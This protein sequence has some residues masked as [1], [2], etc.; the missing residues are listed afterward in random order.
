MK[1]ILSIV[2]VLGFTANLAAQDIH[3]SNYDQ[4]P[5][6]LNPANTGISQGSHRAFMNYKKQWNSVSNGFK[7]MGASYDLS[8]SKSRNNNYLGMG[9]NF[10]SDKSGL[11]SMGTTLFDLFVAYHLKLDQNSSFS[12][13]IKGGIHQRSITSN[14]MQWGNQYDASMEGFNGGLTSS[15]QG[16]FGSFTNAD[17]SAGLAW[18]YNSSTSTLSSNDAF[19]ARVGFS[20]HH[21]HSPYLS[22]TG[23]QNERLARKFV[24]HGKVR[25]GIPNTNLQIEPKTVITFQSTAKEIMFGSNFRYILNEK[26]KYTSFNGGTA[27]SVGVNYR[28]KD[29]IILSSM[30]EYGKFAVGINYDIN[31]SQ[32][33]VASGGR[34]GV[35]FCLKFITPNPFGGSSDTPSF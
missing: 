35:E 34:G 21:L 27:L 9:I 33:T 32:L 24:F 31:I 30:L 11:L 20:I 10:Y 8:L 17:F 14:G 18:N 19:L 2:I 15:E 7:T 28:L 25:Y 22:Y 6:Q 23:G 12:G 13:G 5:L 1:N 26:S 29:A 4:A 3:F 16:T